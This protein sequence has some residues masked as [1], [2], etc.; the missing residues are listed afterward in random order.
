[1][2][3][4]AMDTST[5]ICS[6]AIMVENALEYETTFRVR[7]GHAGS[8]LPAIDTAMDQTGIKKDQIDIIA[9]SLGPGSF[10][11]IRI[12]IATAK[13]LGYALDCP[14]T[15]IPTLDIIA[16]GA[17]RDALPSSLPIMPVLDAR[18]GEVFCALYT[19]TGKPLHGP[20]NIRPEKTVPMAEGHTLFI[21]NAIALYRDVF[22]GSLGEKYHEGPEHLWY[23]RASVLARMANEYPENRTDPL[24]VRESDATLLLKKLKTPGS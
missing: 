3:I 11:G 6:V 2:N 20:V 9:V 22:T 19:S 15:G 23:P 4:L 16:R 18:K 13:G 10:T 21:G 12:G 17:S 14:V 8:L 7:K 1:M 24:Y 5:D